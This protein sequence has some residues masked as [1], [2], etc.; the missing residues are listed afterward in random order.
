M[1]LGEFV[2]TGGEL[3]AMAFLDAT[4]RLVE[5]A[6]DAASAAAES[7]GE[8]GGL[9]HPAYTRPPVFRG[10]DVPAVLLSGDQPAIAEWRR[11]QSRARAAAR[12]AGGEPA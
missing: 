5:G 4:V 7:W 2:L 1:S 8:D 9:D 10:V 6:I 3:A 11:E 12:N